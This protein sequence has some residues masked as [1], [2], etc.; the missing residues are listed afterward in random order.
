[1]KQPKTDTLKKLRGILQDTM[2]VCADTIS[3]IERGDATLG[4]VQQKLYYQGKMDGFASL[5][6]LL[7]HLGPAI[8]E[9]AF[10]LG[11]QLGQEQ[12]GRR[13]ADR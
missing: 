6:G 10:E 3:R 12:S 1:M 2:T 5:L 4:L 11:S 13:S 8:E 9:E 7:D